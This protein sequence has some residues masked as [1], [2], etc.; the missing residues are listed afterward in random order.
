MERTIPSSLSCFS[1]DTPSIITQ[2][3]SFYLIHFFFICSNDEDCFF[4]TPHNALKMAFFLL[5]SIL[6]DSD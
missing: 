3:I 5:F 2:T 4:V 6:P 1:F